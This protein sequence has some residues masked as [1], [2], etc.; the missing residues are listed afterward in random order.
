ALLQETAR[1]EQLPV[2]LRDRLRGDQESWLLAPALRRDEAGRG[3]LLALDDLDRGTR[4]GGREF[5][6][7]LEDRHRLRTADD[8][9]DALRG[10]VLSAQRNRLELVRLQ[11][12]DDRVGDAVVRGDDAVDLVA[13]PDQHLL[14]DR[15][16]LLV[17]P[18]G[19]EL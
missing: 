2:R 11:R 9:L 8:V 10:R 7:V 5:P 18:P 1:D 6:D 3:R 12:D 15:A 17:V 19:H 13:R 4:G 14:E 16:G